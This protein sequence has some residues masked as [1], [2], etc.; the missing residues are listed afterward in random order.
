MI[1][2]TIGDALLPVVIGYLMQY[3]GDQTLLYLALIF[4]VILA[5]I[6]SIVHILSVGLI[7]SEVKIINTA[8]ETQSIELQ[9]S[10]EKIR[11]RKLSQVMS[12]EEGESKKSKLSGGS[13]SPKNKKGEHLKLLLFW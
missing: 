1:G 13:F 5:I 4:A 3:T 9:I 2:T 12:V 10:V 11:E 8:A 6:F 7:H